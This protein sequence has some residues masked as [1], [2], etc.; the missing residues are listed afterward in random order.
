LLVEDEKQIIEIAKKMLQKMG[1]RVIEATNGKE[2]LEQY[3][4]YA[5]DIT[6]VM[7]DLGMPVMDGYTLFHELK[8]LDS[9]LPIIISSGFGD[10][11]ITSQISREDIASIVSKPYNFIQLQNVIK[12]VVENKATVSS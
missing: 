8:R 7:T 5:N 11:D 12:S 4:K 9:S 1:F 10:S 3:Q 6:L 2:G